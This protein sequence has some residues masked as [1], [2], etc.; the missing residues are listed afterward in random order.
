MYGKMME[1]F[2]KG[3]NV[4]EAVKVGE[5]TLVDPKQ[6]S[7]PDIVRAANS[8]IIGSLSNL[9]GSNTVSVERVDSGAPAANAPVPRSD[10]T[11]GPAPAAP[12]A[13]AFAGSSGNTA[14]PELQNDLQP[15]P[16]A[17]ASGAPEKAP[18]QVNDAVPAP[19]ADSSS[20]AAPA[21]NSGTQAQAAPANPTTESTSKKKKKKVLGIF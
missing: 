21:A 16:S 8:S 5:P 11:S 7:A 15:A 6:A 4:T 10:T 14:V 17:D 1:N 20:Q 3:P 9:N 19:S 2:R 18:P 13:G 12:M